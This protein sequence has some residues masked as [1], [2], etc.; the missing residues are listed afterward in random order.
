MNNKNKITDKELNIPVEKPA[1]LDALLERLT[2][3]DRS[4]MIRLGGCVFCGAIVEAD[5][6]EDDLSRKEYTISGMCQ[7]CQDH[8]FGIDE[9][10]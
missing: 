9:V 10:E 8:A 6:F 3:V 7:K 1:A 2:G 5:D 4:T